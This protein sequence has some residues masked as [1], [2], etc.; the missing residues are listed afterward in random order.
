MKSL[1]NLLLTISVLLQA[2]CSSLQFS[3]TKNY[4]KEKITYL[5][6]LAAE[7]NLA[8]VTE[9][10]YDPYKKSRKIIL[11]LNPLDNENLEK[12]KGTH[13]ENHPKL[14]N[15]FG[16][17]EIIY[18]D[19][20]STGYSYRD[21]LIINVSCRHPNKNIVGAF[22]I[23]DAEAYKKGVP[24]MNYKQE[25]ICKDNNKSWAV[26]S[27]NN[28]KWTAPDEGYYHLMKETEKLI[29]K[30]VGGKSESD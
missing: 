19:F 4:K 1:A 11:D 7:K 22:L 3:K 6:N 14:Y 5:I 2:S 17:D 18:I 24:I 21:T 23:E 30:L 29:E 9:V 10:G 28:K 27:K 15:L 12:T 8:K 20:D 26:S 25:I 16:I 13:L